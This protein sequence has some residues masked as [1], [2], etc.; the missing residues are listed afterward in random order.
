[1]DDA[2]VV[3]ELVDRRAIEELI[4]AYCRHFDQ[5]EPDSVAALFTEDATVDYGPEFPNVV[6]AS[7]IAAAV[8]VGLE[9]TFAATSHHVSNIEIAFDGPD[10]ATGS[11]YLYAW[12]RYRDA[13]PDGELWGRYHHRFERTP[14]GWR[15]ARLVLTAAG[16]RHFHRT[17]MHPTGRRSAQ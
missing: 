8:A 7:S 2:A 17:A 4:Y 11:T 10:R 3:R 15:I 5:N 6:G 12:H 13:S 9:Q 1:V 14:D 16:S